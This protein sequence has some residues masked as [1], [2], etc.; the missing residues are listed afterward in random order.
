MHTR[1]IRPSKSGAFSNPAPAH[2]LAWTISGSRVA[3]NVP[4]VASATEQPGEGDVIAHM[5]NP[6]TSATRLEGRRFS[7][8]SCELWAG[9]QP[10][11]QGA[12]YVFALENFGRSMGRSLAIPSTALTRN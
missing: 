10:F 1:A 12:D 5:R 3:A 8:S 9:R 6:R 4:L 2:R 11:H 7:A